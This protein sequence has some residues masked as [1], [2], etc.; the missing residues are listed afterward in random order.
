MK[1]KKICEYLCDIGL[2]EI[3][4]INWFLKVYSQIDDNKCKR[5]LD[6]LKIALFSYIN[7]ISKND[8]LLFKICRNIVDSFINK[9]VVLKYKSL[10]SINNINI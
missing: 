8:N 4:D 7:S 9:Q 2:L 3:N 6:R 5:E 1:I 10:N